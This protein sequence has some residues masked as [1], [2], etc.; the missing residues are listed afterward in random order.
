MRKK[1]VLLL[2]ILFF[3][4]V[5]CSDDR[6]ADQRYWAGI[7]YAVRGEFKKAEKEFKGT[8]E[9]DTANKP[10]RE[11]LRVINDVL[12]KKIKDRAAVYF[13]KAVS[14]SNKGRLDE[15]SSYFSMAIKQNPD[16]VQAYYER[17]LVN[18][19]RGEYQLAAGDF[20]RAIELSRNDAEAYNN[21]GLVFAKGMKKYDLAIADFGSAIGLNPEFAEAYDNR[22]IAYRMKDNDKERACSDWKKACE[23][24]RCSSYDLAKQN[25]YCE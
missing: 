16:F 21:R 19:Y 10:A 13:F 25:G 1:H 24:D 23:L 18:A 2:V 9:I 6:T 4:I 14:R 20:T 12:L 11:S 5:G 8:V 15:A 22:G 7:D 17:G 3:Q